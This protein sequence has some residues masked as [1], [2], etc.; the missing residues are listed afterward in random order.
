MKT[1]AQYNTFLNCYYNYLGF[2]IMWPGVS[3]RLGLQDVCHM[4][5]V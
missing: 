2:W 1:T 3:N 4:N 5:L